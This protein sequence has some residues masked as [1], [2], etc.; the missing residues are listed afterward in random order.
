[1]KRNSLSKAAALMLTGAMTLGLLA[2]CTGAP[3]ETTPPEAGIY[4]PGTYTATAKGYGGTVTVNLTVDANN[5]TAVTI[6]GPDET[7]AIGGEALKTLPDAVKV[8]NS[9]EVDTVAGATLT[10]NAVKE[11]VADALAQAKGEAAEAAPLAFTPGTMWHL[12]LYAA[13]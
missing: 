1:M 7:P 3:E 8:A 11:A 13:H 4:T 2:G 9:A 6:D 10:S 5:I 12:S